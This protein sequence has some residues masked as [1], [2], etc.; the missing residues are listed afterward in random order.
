MQ[1]CDRLGLLRPP[2]ARTGRLLPPRSV[3]KAE[4]HV[5]RV[6]PTSSRA[7]EAACRVRSAPGD[8]G[9]CLLPALLLPVTVIIVHFLL[10]PARRLLPP[11]GNEG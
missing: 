11:A 7:P 3:V 1:V 8:P 4:L 10:T 9:C 5:F 6:C 2:A